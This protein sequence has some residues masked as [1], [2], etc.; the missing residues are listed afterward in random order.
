MTE[1][2]TTNENIDDSLQERGEAPE[3]N[4]WWRSWKWLVSLAVILVLIAGAVAV[5][6]TTAGGGDR[7][8][9]PGETRVETSEGIAA[10]QAGTVDDPYP[11]GSTIVSDDWEVTVN[12]VD[13]DATDEV[14]SADDENVE[15]ATG[16]VYLMANI[17]ATYVGEDQAGAL[18]PLKVQYL[19]DQ[20]VE[21]LPQDTFVV[22]PDP[23]EITAALTPGASLTGNVV[24]SVPA[25]TMKSAVL[26]VSATEK[27]KI[28]FI[29]IHK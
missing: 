9:E 21:F 28:F 26:Q 14:L 19:D 2:A 23:F 25:D 15:P 18:P 3:R 24:V 10:P 20:G 27:G 5:S 11:I 4:R 1:T 16:E 12:A 22:T 6:L 7:A 13:L 8:R 29:A 17:T